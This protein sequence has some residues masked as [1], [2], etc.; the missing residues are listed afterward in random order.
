MKK[1][2]VDNNDTS[3]PFGKFWSSLVLTILNDK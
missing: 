2:V 3:I 1:M